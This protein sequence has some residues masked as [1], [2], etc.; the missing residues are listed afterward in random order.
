MGDCCWGR[1]L[2]LTE[3]RVLLEVDL[4]GTGDCWIY[5]FP[6]LPSHPGNE[7]M[8]ALCGPLLAWPVQGICLRI[9]NWSWSLK[10]LGFGMG[11]PL[12]ILSLS[13]KTIPGGGGL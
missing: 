4:G 13:H 5:L 1:G 8:V 12:D 3:P 9:S 11:K 6:Q 2:G 10:T 7:R